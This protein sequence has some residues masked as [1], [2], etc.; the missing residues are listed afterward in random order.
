MKSAILFLSGGLDSTAML[1]KAF[2]ENERKHLRV[3]FIELHNRNQRWIAERD[4]VTAIL[5]WFTKRGMKFS[6]TTSRHDFSGTPDVILQDMHLFYFVGA[7][8]LRTYQDANEIRLGWIKEEWDKESVRDRASN[9]LNILKGA[10]MKPDIRLNDV[11][12]TFPLKRMSKKDVYLYLPE[13]LKLMTWSCRK[14]IFEGNRYWICNECHACKLIQK[15]H[16]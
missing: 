1:Y 12:V 3:H 8:L 5:N 10:V 11:E 16:Q 9:A 6:Y 15:V 4:S 2:I 13:Q 7:T 14:P